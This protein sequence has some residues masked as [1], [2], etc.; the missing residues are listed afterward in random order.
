MEFQVELKKFQAVIGKLDLLKDKL[1]MKRQKNLMLLLQQQMQDP[2]VVL[3]CLKALLNPMVVF[4][5]IRV[6]N[7]TNLYFWHIRC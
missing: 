7:E 3:L 4:G 5:F 1:F 2:L 6:D